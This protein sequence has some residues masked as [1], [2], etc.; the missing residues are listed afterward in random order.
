[1]VIMYYPDFGMIEKKEYDQALEQENRVENYIRS[2]VEKRSGGKYTV[3]LTTS[4]G[5]QK[6]D[7]SNTDHKMKTAFEFEENKQK[8]VGCKQRKKKK[9][10]HRRILS[11][12]IFNFVLLLFFNFF[13]S[14]IL[15]WYF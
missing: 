1:M 6:M 8:N 7:F 2:Q 15:K 11:K 3:I 5:T 10:L 14:I 4:E 9:C 12:N 13:S